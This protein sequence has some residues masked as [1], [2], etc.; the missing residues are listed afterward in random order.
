MRS[1][2]M[3]I[4]A[5]LIILAFATATYQRNAIW[6]NPETLGKDNIKK[7]PGKV[8]V[9]YDVGNYFVTQGRIDEAIELFQAAIRVRPTSEEYNNLGLAYE[10]KGMI[11]PAMEMFQFA[12]Y[13]DAAN[14][15]AYNNLGKVSLLYQN[16]IDDAITLFNKAIAL[17]PGYIDATINLA[18]AHIRGRRF[19][20]AVPLLNVVLSKDPS[21]ED[22][23]Y[24]LGAAYHCLHD[25]GAAQRELDILRGT[26][27]PLAVRLDAF[28]SRPCDKGRQK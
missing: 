7:S 4:A 17:K 25:A 23:H 20:D 5:I 27:S 9:Y 26:G 13:L 6:R 24:N 28:T 21:R 22:A 18:A 8:R 16:R 1:P 19:Q 15:V 12:I 10:S 11:G 2:I 3:S 14:A